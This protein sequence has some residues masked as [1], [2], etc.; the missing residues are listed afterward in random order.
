MTDERKTTPQAEGPA[1]APDADG[2]PE[3][4]TVEQIDDGRT[5]RRQL[6]DWCQL[7]GLDAGGTKAD[8]V[9]RL[10]RLYAPR[11]AFPTA[12]PC[13]RCGC[14]RTI[15]TSTYAKVQYRQCL[16]AVCRHRFPVLGKRV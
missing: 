7:R 3:A 10:R 5:T 4:L 8:L 1:T 2:V 12:A 14:Q 6:A 11:Y 13:P 15:V 16:M 9:G